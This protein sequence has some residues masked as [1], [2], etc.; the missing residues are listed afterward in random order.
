MARGD[1]CCAG[2]RDDGMRLLIYALESSGASTFCQFCGQREDSIAILDL[3]SHVLTPRLDVP[4]DVVVKATATARYSLDQHIESFRPDQTILFVRDPV[5][6]YA[7][8]SKYSY[9]NEVGTIDEKFQR[10]DRDLAAWPADLV[11]RY[12]AFIARDPALPPRLAALGWPADPSWYDLARST[13]AIQLH[14]MTRSEWASAEFD[15]SWGPGNIKGTKIVATFNETAV[16]ASMHDHVR[17]LCPF[18][19]QLYGNA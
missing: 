9:A 11:F 8:L 16:D 13:T 18:M 4:G 3:W 5:R 17:R 12:E 14:N 7:S 10:F 15:Q 6:N 2:R 19:T 1:Q